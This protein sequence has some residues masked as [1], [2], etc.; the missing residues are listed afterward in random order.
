V[1]SIADLSEYQCSVLIE[2]AGGIQNEY[3]HLLD[4]DLTLPSHDTT[5]G[6]AIEFALNRYIPTMLTSGKFD[7]ASR[8]SIRYLIRVLGREQ[9]LMDI[10][11]VIKK[12]AIVKANRDNNQ[13]LFHESFNLNYELER[14]QPQIQSLKKDLQKP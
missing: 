13:K 11:E 1:T 5:A 10:N 14:I 4:F 3:R 7:Y 6:N 12:D 2:H 9:V 8:L